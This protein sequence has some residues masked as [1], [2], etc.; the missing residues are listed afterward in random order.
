MC[1]VLQ[2]ML[3]HRVTQQP[4]HPAL[5]QQLLTYNSISTRGVHQWHQHVLAALTDSTLATQ[6]AAVQSSAQRD[7][8][9][10]AAATS[11]SE[12]LASVT[13]QYNLG[14]VHPRT[15]LVDAPCPACEGVSSAMLEYLPALAVL[16]P[17]DMYCYICAD[18]VAAALWGKYLQKDS[19][20]PAAWH[21]L[22][23]K[24]FESD[25]RIR[26]AAVFE[27]L[28]GLGSMQQ[29]TVQLA[30]HSVATSRLSRTRLSAGAADEVTGWVPNLEHSCFQDIDLWG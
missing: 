3:R 10:P 12:V 20:D 13:R 27:S 18:L 8:D 9:P 4:P 30:P 28:L 5:I 25:A 26:T 22:R 11:C 21:T 2:A 29:L 1:L 23:Q 19:L 6:A 7:Q 17:G 24:L 16:Q 15:E 14:A